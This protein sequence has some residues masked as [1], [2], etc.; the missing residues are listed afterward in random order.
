MKFE[1]IDLSLEPLA[2]IARVNHVRMRSVAQ[3][4]PQA[5][6]LR[7]AP[8]EAFDEVFAALSQ[9]SAPVAASKLPSS[10]AKPSLNAAPL[11]A[12]EA[13]LRRQH[14]RLAILLREIDS[15]ISA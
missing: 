15:G 9:K 6:V 13:N 10:F 2:A 1:P 8:P 14:E 3:S 12:L 7:P 11:V 5:T 4:R